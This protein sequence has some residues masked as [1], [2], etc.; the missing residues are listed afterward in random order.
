MQDLV[1]GT[2]K[3]EDDKGSEGSSLFS[4]SSF[5]VVDISFIPKWT[6]KAT[7]SWSLQIGF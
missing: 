5:I 7:A 4:A 1:A 6:I 3:K 2:K